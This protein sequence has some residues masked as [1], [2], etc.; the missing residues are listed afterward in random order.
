MTAMDHHHRDVITR[1]KT[2]TRELRDAIPDVW[3]GFADLH[4]HAMADG[5]EGVGLFRDR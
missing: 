4:Q 1:L 2:P 5:A 3:A